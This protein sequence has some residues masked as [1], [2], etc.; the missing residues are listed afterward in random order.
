M[1]KELSP[2]ERPNLFWGLTTKHKTYCLNRGWR[3]TASN[4]WQNRSSK[5]G[6]TLP[7]LGTPGFVNSKI[8]SMST[9]TCY[10]KRNLRIKTPR[11]ALVAQ[12][13]PSWTRTQVLGW[14]LPLLICSP[15][16]SKV[17]RATQDSLA[18]KFNNLIL[19]LLLALGELLALWKL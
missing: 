9:K 5:D 3:S 1:Q 12:Q 17:P 10:H 7:C 8:L 4:W 16:I 11:W 14:C 13:R 6:R 2:L 19:Q 15:T 18:C